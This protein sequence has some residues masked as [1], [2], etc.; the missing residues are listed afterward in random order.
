MTAIMFEIICLKARPNTI[1]FGNFNGHGKLAVAAN[2]LHMHMFPLPCL[3][4]WLCSLPNNL[5]GVCEQQGQ[6]QH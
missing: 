6:G 2:L 4:I 3:H 5:L 1:S